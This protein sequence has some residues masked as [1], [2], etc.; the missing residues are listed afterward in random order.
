[1]TSDHM[2]PLFSQRTYN[3]LTRLIL[4]L[5]LSSSCLFTGKG[6]AVEAVSDNDWIIWK[7]SQ[8]RIVSYRK[9]HT[10]GLIEIK[11]KT[12]VSS[13]LAGFILFIEDSTNIPLWFD[14]ASHAKVIE[15]IDPTTHVFQTDFHAIWPISNRSMIIKSHYWQNKNLTIEIAIEDMGEAYNTD[16]ILI[17]VIEAHWLLTPLMNNQISLEYQFIADAQG[18]VPKWL[19]NS[20]TLKSIWRTLKNIEQQ[21][22]ISPWQEQTLS[23][24]KEMK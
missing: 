1:M 24:I 9:I 4:L 14:N 15:V 18:S 19:V 17:K 10:S 3:F 13:S 23:H 22:P 12:Q 5:L 7:E 11:A 20:L 2:F 16:N 8:H 21:L 6:F